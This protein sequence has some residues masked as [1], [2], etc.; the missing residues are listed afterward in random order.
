MSLAKKIFLSLLEFKSR[1]ISAVRGIVASSVLFDC[2]QEVDRLHRYN[3]G[4]ML[5]VL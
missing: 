4:R 1:D 2:F 5:L 3:G